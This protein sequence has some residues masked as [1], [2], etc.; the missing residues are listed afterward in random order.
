MCRYEEGYDE[1]ND[2]LVKEYMLKNGGPIPILEMTYINK[3]QPKP[4]DK[5]VSPLIKTRTVCPLE[6]S[7]MTDIHTKRQ[8]DKQIKQTE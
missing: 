3:T 7:T 2:E 6:R 8:S 4:C 1:H 5:E